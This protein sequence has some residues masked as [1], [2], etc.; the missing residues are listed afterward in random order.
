MTCVITS[1]PIDSVPA[2][3]ACSPDAETVSEGP[4]SSPLDELFSDQSVGR[5]REVRTVLFGRANGNEN[6]WCSGAVFEHGVV[7]ECLH[8]VPCRL[9]QSHLSIMPN[10]R[11]FRYILLGVGGVKRL[12]AIW[13][14]YV[15]SV[16][17]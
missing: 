11:P 2:K 10:T 4:T 15:A 16:R 17:R 8:L 9:T 13:P 1:V 5:H 6:D 14:S 7:D 12:S 3:P